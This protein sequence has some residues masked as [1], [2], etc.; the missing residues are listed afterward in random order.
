MGNGRTAHV[1]Q[2]AQLLVGWRLSRFCRHKASDKAIGPSG[3]R[4]CQQ[5]CCLGEWRMQATKLSLET[6]PSKGSAA[7][8]TREPRTAGSLEVNAKQ[9]KIGVCER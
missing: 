3:V 4:R 7:A 6:P 1:R 5:W 8:Q 9:I 2:A